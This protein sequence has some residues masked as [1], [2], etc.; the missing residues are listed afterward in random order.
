MSP[1]DPPR[2]RR[3]LAAMYCPACKG[4]QEAPLRTPLV[5]QYCGAQTLTASLRTHP[6]E[7]W[8]TWNDRRLL[9]AARIKVGGPMT[10]LELAPHWVAAADAPPDTKQGVSFLCPHCRTT[11]LAV[12]FDVPVCGA[13]P[14]DL[15]TLQRQQADGHL[16]D[17][18][19][20]RIL[21]HREGDTF[22]DL[23]LQPSVD[24][25]HFGHWHGS[26]TAGV[27]S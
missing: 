9:R 13:A 5:C 17:H 16:A 15:P 18:H 2:P 25:S 22:A 3:R 12:F 26:V 11:R 10:L 7:T 24:A 1:R 19:L 27:L 20:G 4:Q 6:L 21:W 14:V 23:T 8:L